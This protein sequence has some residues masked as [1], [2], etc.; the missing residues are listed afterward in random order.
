MAD[1]GGVP[2]A[3]RASTFEIDDRYGKRGNSGLGMPAAY[4]PMYDPGGLG[5]NELAGLH[6]DPWKA[7]IKYPSLAMQL[8]A[9]A[10]AVPGWGKAVSMP[11]AAP[12]AGSLAWDG[13]RAMQQLN[14]DH[15]AQLNQDYWTNALGRALEG[16]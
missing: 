5:G 11:L 13:Y 6:S 9:L 16:K 12:F 7:A 3:W 15:P 10:S 2:A 14:G 1:N 8:M 4:G